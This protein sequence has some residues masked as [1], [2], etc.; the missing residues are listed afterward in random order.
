MFTLINRFP[1]IARETRQQI[2]DAAGFIIGRCPLISGSVNKFFMLGADPPALAW[3]FAFCKNADQISAIFNQ[4]VGFARVSF[5][6]HH[7]LLA[8][9]V[10]NENA[11]YQ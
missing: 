3:F 6:A 4:G 2:T 10:S 8:K 7:G 5:C 9:P 1:P 11:Y